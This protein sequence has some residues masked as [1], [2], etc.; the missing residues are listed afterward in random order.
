MHEH[1]QLSEREQF[2][3]DSPGAFP[4]Q[5]TARL[6]AARCL[7]ALASSV[8]GLG[9]D[10]AQSALGAQ[11]LKEAQGCI[12][13]YVATLRSGQLPPEKCVVEIK[14]LLDE[15]LQGHTEDVSYF[16]SV[17]VSSSIDAYYAD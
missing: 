7:T 12:H 10:S 5:A 17:L 3:D 13:E 15:C 9:P 6:A 2:N 14:H 8:V 16:A 4:A 11:G 1:G